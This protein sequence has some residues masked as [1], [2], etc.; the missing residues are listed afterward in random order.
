MKY[1]RHVFPLL[2]MV[3][4]YNDRYEYAVNY[5]DKMMEMVLSF[6]SAVKENERVFTKGIQYT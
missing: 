1:L 5:K 6:K 2:L 4:C 3:S